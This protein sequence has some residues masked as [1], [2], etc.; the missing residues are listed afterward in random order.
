MGQLGHTDAR[1]TPNVY[2]QVL[3]RQ[4]VD[5]ALIWRLM[6]FPDEPEERRPM[7]VNETRNGTTSAI[8]DRSGRRQASSSHRNPALAGLSRSGRGWVRTSDL[9]RVRRA[10]SR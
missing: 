8:G 4:R 5:E 2:A 7:A 3:Q 1:L 10:L 9:S 6:R